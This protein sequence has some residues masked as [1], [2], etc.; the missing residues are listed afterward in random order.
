MN[1][2]P[3]SPSFRGRLGLLS[4]AMA[5]GVAV[6][7]E[8]D[9]IAKS[10]MESSGLFGLAAFKS[11]GES[12]Q[13]AD[14]RDDRQ[15]TWFTGAMMKFVSGKKGMEGRTILRLDKERIW[16]VDPA[17]KEYTEMTFDEYRALLDRPMQQMQGQGTESGKPA[18]QSAGEVTVK[19]ERPGKTFSVSG[20]TGEQVIATVRMPYRDS[21]RNRVDTLV[22]KYDAFLSADKGLASEFRGFNEAWAKKMRMDLAQ[23]R[24]LELL[25]NYLEKPMTKLGKEIGKNGEVPLKFTLVAM[26]PLSE[27]DKAAM[28]KG[29]AK[30]DKESDLK[31]PGSVGD[32]AGQAMGKAFGFFKKKHEDG[33]KAEKAA[34][35]A[36]LGV[37]EGYYVITSNA[38][39]YTDLKIAPTAAA[40]YEL[41]QGFKKVEN[42]QTA[43]APAE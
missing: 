11:E 16:N 34:S 23:F 37:P 7:A 31:V 20:F 22:V 3:S 25:F 10:K 19:V 33:K 15:T 1:R 39:E 18:V 29:E 43:S 4:A 28:K 40:D 42:K 17:K 32:A 26:Q 38:F 2:I 30:E 9:V 6:Q 5:L 36:K 27:E 21:V 35:D 13:S 8:A 12:R 41:P 14:K 24:G